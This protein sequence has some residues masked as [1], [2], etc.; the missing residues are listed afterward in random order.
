MLTAG[1]FVNRCTKWG[2]IDMAGTVAQTAEA[3]PTAP[4]R[5]LRAT[6]WIDTDLTRRVLTSFIAEEIGKFGI[7]RAVV[8]VSGGIDS[9]L[10]AYL[11]VEALGPGKVLAV[12]MPYRASNPDS[13]AHGLLCVERL[14]VEHIVV[15]VTPQVDPYFER[16][17]EMSNLRR[18]NMM[19]RERMQ[20]LYDQSE[21]TG[22]LVVGTSNKTEMLLGYST[23]YGDSAAAIHP[24]ADL[25]KTQIRQLSTA[26]GVPDVIIGKPPSADLWPGQTDEA[27]LQLTYADVDEVLYFLVDRRMRP[28]ELIE[29]GFDPAVVERVV[30]LVRSA[31]YKRRTPPIAKVSARTIEQDFL[32]LRDWGR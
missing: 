8:A 18:G 9:A 19:A 3:V 12:L 17:P 20:I 32:Y 21:A 29:Q 1:A 10:V 2:R 11:T 23:V 31:Q 5:A 25:Y 26:L 14:G 13:L 27:E 16:F 24:I 4:E 6:L 30:R 15:P 22:A 28:P 7:K